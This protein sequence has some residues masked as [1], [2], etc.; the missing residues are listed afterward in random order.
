[1]NKEIADYVTR[2]GVCQQ[3]K[4]DHQKPT[5]PLE[6]RLILEWKWDNIIMDFV[7][8]LPRGKK[9]NDAIWVIMDKLIKYAM[10]LPIKVIY[11]VEKLVKLYVNEVI[12]L[13][14]ILVSIIFYRDY[15]RVDYGRLLF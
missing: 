12:R 11:P 5:G 7:L 4:V 6:P 13:Y 2:C 9:R 3:V 1:M 10:F 15:G 14:G 8:E